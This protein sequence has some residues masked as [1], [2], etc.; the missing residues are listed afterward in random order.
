[1]HRLRPRKYPGNL[2]VG[3]GEV[4]Y[5]GSR[6]GM[7]SSLILRLPHARTSVNHPAVTSADLSTPINAMDG[8]EL[9]SQDRA[10]EALAFVFFMLVRNTSSKVSWLTASRE[11][12]DENLCCIVYRARHISP[13]L[14]EVVF[15]RK[16]PTK[17][18]CV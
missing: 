15:E 5:R 18:V 1:M 12:R 16:T 9:S 11:D 3:R 2:P 6:R 8:R 17:S 13:W 7:L 10:V 4:I 14:A